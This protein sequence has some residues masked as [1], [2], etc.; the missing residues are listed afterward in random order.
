MSSPK[1]P[2]T[3]RRLLLPAL[4]ALVAATAVHLYCGGALRQ[5]HQVNMDMDHA[6]QSDYLGTARLLHDSQYGFLTTPR[7][8]MPL[9]PFLLSLAVRPGMSDEQFF[10]LAKHAGILFSVLALSLI[11]L[12]ARIHLRIL[13][14]LSLTLVLAFTAF[15]F[16]APYA[17]CEMI[18]YFLFFLAFVL[19]LEMLAASSLKKAAFL[20]LVCAAAYLTKA[21]ILPALALFAFFFILKQLILSRQE[22]TPK[23]RAGL[24]H[25]VVCAVVFLVVVTPYLLETKRV[26]GDWFYNVTSSYGMWCDSYEEFNDKVQVKNGT[27]VRLLDPDRPSMK[28]Y[29]REHNLADAMSR[30]ASGAVLMWRGIREVYPLFP[31]FAGIFAVFALAATIFFPVRTLSAISGR[32]FEVAFLAALPAALL[33]LYA[34][35]APVVSSPRHPL[36][37]Y[38]PFLF[39]ASLAIERILLPNEGGCGNRGKTLFACGH[40]VVFMAL[41]WN[42]PHILYTLSLRVFGGG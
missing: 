11:F 15:M 7:S 9:Y 10:S 22:G 32:P 39:S 29:M 4:F 27:T 28:K 41:L 20:G 33:V 23:A 19:M 30:L 8:K 24:L 17:T 25:L 21:S 18:F 1:T 40:A 35:L 26:F 16:K 31:V 14:A 3:L 5:L 13:S 6:D 12:I 36:T 42:L 37:L 38:A 2:S 34:W